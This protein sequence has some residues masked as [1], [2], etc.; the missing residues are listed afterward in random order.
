MLNK[1]LGILLC[2]AFVFTSIL[3]LANSTPEQIG[4]QTWNALQKK[5]SLAGA[6][7]PLLVR[8]EEVTAA[9]RLRPDKRFLMA[10]AEVD[11]FLTGKPQQP[12]S[13]NYKEDIWTITYKDE[14]V[15]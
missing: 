13:A 15:E 7:S 12:V 14:F 2:V 4:K 5:V 1:I 8:K 10:V 3:Y 9:Y 11:Y 6:P